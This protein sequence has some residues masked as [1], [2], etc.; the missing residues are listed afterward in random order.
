[1][2]YFGASIKDKSSSPRWWDDSPVGLSAIS[3]INTQK[4]KAIKSPVK[5]DIFEAL[6]AIPKIESLATKSPNQPKLGE[7]K[8][9]VSCEQTTKKAIASAMV[10]MGFS[11]EEIGE[12]EPQHSV[13]LVDAL[14]ECNSLDTLCLLGV[15]HERNFLNQQG[16]KVYFVDGFSAALKAIVGF[17][18][19]SFATRLSTGEQVVCLDLEDCRTLSKALNLSFKAVAQVILCHEWS[20]LL[21]VK[22]GYSANDEKLAWA[23]AERFGQPL[24]QGSAHAFDSIRRHLMLQQAA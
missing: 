10:K 4:I 20:H 6:A 17:S 13:G 15:H 24:L 22:A 21:A 19:G 9:T 3:A 5:K 14:A 7:T 2:R 8:M 1:M 16:I 18:G 12:I 23:L 11:S